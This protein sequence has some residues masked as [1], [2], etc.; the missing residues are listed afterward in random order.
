[1]RDVVLWA[2]VAVVVSRGGVALAANPPTAAGGHAAAVDYDRDIKPILSARCFQCH[3]PDA[4]T[5]KADLRLDTQR[6][7]FATLDEG[8]AISPGHPEA[9]VAFRRV[10]TSD[11]AERMPPPPKGEGKDQPLTPTQIELV[12]RW[13]A[14][15]AVWRAHWSLEPIVPTRP[16]TDGG[17]GWSKNFIDSFVEQRLAREGIAHGERASPLTLLRRVALDL[18]GLPPSPEAVKAFVADRRPGAYERAVDRLLNTPAYAEHMTRYWL[19]LARYG[20]T[21]GLHRDENRALWPYRDWVINAFAQNMAFDR[22]TTLQLAGDLLPG[23]TL[24]DRVATGFLRANVTTSE[25][26]AIG[27]EFLTRYAADRAETV[28]TTWLGLTARCASCHDH[29]YDPITQKDFYQLTAYWSGIDAFAMDENLERVPPCVQLPTPAQQ[30]ERARLARSIA[31]GERALLRAP[32][33]TWDRA[34][35]AW[36]ARVRARSQDK[37]GS[38]S[39]T[40]L[41]DWWALGCIGWGSVHESLGRGL[42]LEGSSIDLEVPWTSQGHVFSWTKRPEWSDAVIVDE[43]QGDLCA[44]YLFRSI[45]TA[46]AR[47]LSVS[48]GAKDGVKVWLNGKAVLEKLTYSQATVDQLTLNLELTSGRNQLLVKVA[49]QSANGQLFFAPR[50]TT[51][52][53]N[54]VS[55][56]VLRLM[57]IAPGKRTAAQMAAVRS[58]YRLVVSAD[59]ALARK[60]SQLKQDRDAWSALE[61]QVPTTLVAAEHTPQRPVFVLDRGQ[62]DLPR[63]R[64]WPNVPSALHPL[65][66]TAPRNRLG[67]AQ[68]LFA[69]DN[70]LTARVTVNRFWQQIFGVGLVKTSEDFGVQGERPSHPELLDA[71]AYE[72]KSSG[73]DVKALLRLLV[74][75]ATYQ[76]SGA[77]EASKWLSD[78]ENRLLARGP[79]GRLDAEVLRDQALA[80]SG[81][82]VRRVGGRSVKPPQPPGLWEEGSLP[83]A[84]TNTFVP[85][86]GDDVLRRSLYT[87]IKRTSPPP[88]MLTF[89]APSRESCTAR[90]ERTNTPM[91]ALALLNEPQFVAAARALAQTAHRQKATLQDR[92]VFVMQRA[93]LRSPTTSEQQALEQL[94]AQES[95]SHPQDPLRGLTSV[96]SVVMNLDEFISKE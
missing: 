36:E 64:V 85:D 46:S 33:A 12:R 39:Q 47:T 90:R 50:A 61:R 87:F 9:S 63:E 56:N 58:Y 70:P 71:L 84:N 13:I 93:L 4:G 55:E 44:T 26:G 30:R 62:Y 14:Q 60:R 59:S 19:D 95:Q 80:V 27:E 52:D 37:T 35:S 15:G 42:D 49:N 92:I 20:D 22:F 7:L 29:K 40:K 72:F 18:T 83:G 2:A 34:Q 82:L 65:P 1:M 86:T 16:P 91:Q 32:N 96:A 76:Q 57:A 45:E 43:L 8:P 31:D 68:W 69:D 54:I 53:D 25:G 10:A 51:K 23:A 6:G 66:P 77:A 5:R 48:L 28:A 67:F 21:H 89:D 75:S 24:S 74:T 78:P 79:R 41:S 81:L 94:W 11:L 73:W 38:L 17:S 88:T 3:G